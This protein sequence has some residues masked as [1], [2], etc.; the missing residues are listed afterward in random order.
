MSEKWPLDESAVDGFVAATPLE[1][2]ARFSRLDVR[3]DDAAR[4]PVALP[5]PA[6]T[7]ATA[8]TE[9]LACPSPATDE[10]ACR[11]NTPGTCSNVPDPGLRFLQ[12]GASIIP[13]P[14]GDRWM[15]R[16][17]R[18]D[19]SMARDGVLFIALAPDREQTA[20]VLW[21]LPRHRD[22]NFTTRKLHDW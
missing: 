10:F 3:T 14:R 18:A 2:P 20:D 6:P 19:S 8:P 11:G 5:P 22:A 9:P 13:V 15:L 1:I 16:A 4:Q 17:T 7:P 21:S 12:C